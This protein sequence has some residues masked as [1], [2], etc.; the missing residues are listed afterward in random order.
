[1]PLSLSPMPLILSD[2]RPWHGP[3]AVYRKCT[4]GLVQKDLDPD[5]LAAVAEGY[6]TYAPYEQAG[7]AEQAVRNADQVMESRSRWLVRNLDVAKLIPDDGVALDY[8]CGNGAFLH[9]LGGAHPRLILEGADIGN[10]MTEDV[11]GIP[12]IRSYIELPFN[13]AHTERYSLI[14]LIHVLE[15]VAEPVPLLIDLASRLAPGGRI[16]VQVPTYTMNPFDLAIA[17]HLSHFTAQSLADLSARC[18]L[19]VVLG[20]E[21]LVRKEL[22]LVLAVDSSGVPRAD[23]APKAASSGT[24]FD[25]AS[26]VHFLAKWLDLIDTFADAREAPMV[27]GSSISA[28]WIISALGR[29]GTTASLLLDDDPNRIGGQFRGI[30]IRS[31][32]TQSLPAQRIL[33]PLIPS[34]ATTVATRLAER[35]LHC[36]YVR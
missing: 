14:S 2:C 20:P 32:E 9:A 15:H 36:D 19:T 31:P 1:M 6:Q 12:G 24:V 4:C 28:S 34:L 3:N 23:R 17:D 21:E 22:T 30:P 29:E 33:V 5:F 18:G 25:I 8:G 16:V 13:A 35:G 11:L 7:G 26:S 27:F 10:H